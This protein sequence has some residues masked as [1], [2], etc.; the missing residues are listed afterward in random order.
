MSTKMMEPDVQVEEISQA[1]ASELFEAAARRWY[2]ISGRAFIRAYD[3]L[4]LIERDTAK[5]QFVDS[6]RRLARR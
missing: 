1:E 5:A 2:H 4:C 3:S 6:L